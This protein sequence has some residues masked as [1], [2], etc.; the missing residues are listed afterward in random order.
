MTTGFEGA[1]TSKFNSALFKIYR[2]NRC[3]SNV[4]NYWRSG[5]FEEINWELDIIWAELFVDSDSEHKDKMKELNSELV[6]LKKEKDI[7]KYVEKLRE[8]WFYLF[9][10]EK[11]E[12][13]GKS[14]FNEDEASLI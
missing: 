9:E 1:E 7:N 13:L 2:L 6:K 14:Y 11:F 3:W 5:K 8:K 12:G 10:V 4:N